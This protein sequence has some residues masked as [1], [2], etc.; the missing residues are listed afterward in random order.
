MDGVIKTKDL[1]AGTLEFDEKNYKGNI[2]LSLPNDD[3]TSRCQSSSA[4][5]G[6]ICFFHYIS[7]PSIE[8]SVR[9][10]SSELLFTNIPLN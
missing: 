10:D 8:V 9:V 5:D 6:E 3:G 1:I 4:N 2:K 7:P